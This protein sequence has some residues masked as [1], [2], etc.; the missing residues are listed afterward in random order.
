MTG[1][2]LVIPVVYSG[3]EQV[4]PGTAIY[5]K[6]CKE[7]DQLKQTVKNFETELIQVRLILLFFKIFFLDTTRSKDFITRQGQHTAAIFSGLLFIIIINIITCTILLLS[8]QVNEELHKVRL[9]A[10]S[11]ATPPPPPPPGTSLP[12]PQVL[13][14]IEG[15]RDDARLEVKELRT[16]NQSLKERLGMMR[17]RKEREEEGEEE[18]DEEMMYIR[19][20]LEE[21][22]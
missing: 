16:E 13:S 2:K 9:N 17:E 11:A 20:Q 15:E 3:L 1:S 7:R 12:P 14:R 5:D 4:L 19:S 21:V 10:S 8:L 18:E 22:L 6:I